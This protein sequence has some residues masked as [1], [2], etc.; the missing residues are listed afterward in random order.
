MTESVQQQA[1]ES[2]DDQ[3]PDTG[4]ESQ[5]SD[6]ST[7]W[8][9]K[10]D[11]LLRDAR[12]HEERAKKNAEAARRLADLERSQMSE[13][14]KARAEGLDAGRSEVLAQVAQER[15]TSAFRIALAGR[16]DVDVDE[17]LDGVDLAKFRDDEGRADQK[18]I[19]SW[20]AKVAPAP[21]TQSDEAQQPRQLDMGQGARDKRPSASESNMPQFAADLEARL[22]GPRH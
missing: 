3:A 6:E 21:K 22:N 14:E 1:A 17:L 7:D 9:A 2:A 8:K 16:A 4:A 11:A 15:V 20:I 13:I 12:K 5:E 10:H 19:E 18:R